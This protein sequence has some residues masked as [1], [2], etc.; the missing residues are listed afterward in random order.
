VSAAGPRDLNRRHF[1][2]RNRARIDATRLRP[3]VCDSILGSLPSEFPH[4]PCTL[5]IQV[6]MPVAQKGSAGAIAVSVESIRNSGSP[7]LLMISRRIEG[8][9]WLILAGLGC[10]YG[11][12]FVPLVELLAT[13]AGTRLDHFILNLDSLTVFLETTAS[14]ASCPLCGPRGWHC[15]Q[16][17]SAGSEEA[18]RGVSYLP[19]DRQ[20]A[21]ARAAV[22]RWHLTAAV[23]RGQTCAFSAVHGVSDR[24]PRTKPSDIRLIDRSNV[25]EGDIGLRSLTRWPLP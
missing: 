22:N 23:H 16:R 12:F 18:S 2:L 15:A 20:R 4:L 24:P 17:S 1:R 14:T 21:Q 19:R 3:S 11:G 6:A 8:R 10:V 25:R 7:V 5:S 9:T 13:P